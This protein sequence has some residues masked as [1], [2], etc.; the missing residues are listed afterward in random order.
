MSLKWYYFTCKGSVTIQYYTL[1]TGHQTN[2]LQNKYIFLWSKVHFRQPWS[3]SIP[4]R[5]SPNSCYTIYIYI[6]Q[7]SNASIGV[8]SNIT[9]WPRV[10]SL[11]F[12]GHVL[13]VVSFV[14]VSSSLWVWQNKFKHKD[15]IIYRLFKSSVLHFCLRFLRIFCEP[16]AVRLERKRCSS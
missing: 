11:H 3:D 13:I 7:Y 16:C 6:L 10:A 15:D 1:Y 8:H 14:L 12:R 4:F 5:L 2:L 9:Y